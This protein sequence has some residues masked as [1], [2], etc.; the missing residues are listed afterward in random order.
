MKISSILRGL[1]AY[2]AGEAR[3]SGA[4]WDG[5]WA[6]DPYAHPDISA[7]SERE[8]ADL[9]PTHMPA[10]RAMGAA[11]RPASCA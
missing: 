8:R 6:D 5:G 9:P 4:P 2:P 10:R 7:M 3:A 1:L 11:F